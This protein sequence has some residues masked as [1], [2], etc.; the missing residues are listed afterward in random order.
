MAESLILSLVDPN[1]VGQIDFLHLT[2]RVLVIEVMIFAFFLSFFFLSYMYMCIGLMQD[3]RQFG[4][5]ILEQVSGTRGLASGLKFLCSD[6]S[7]L[8]SIFWGLRHAC[9]L[10][11][12]LIH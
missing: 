10:V 1:D 3:V 12:I 9:K 6:G 4:K 8:S 7:S 11:K 5:C 2:D